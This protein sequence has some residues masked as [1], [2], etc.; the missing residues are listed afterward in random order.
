M[1]K[2]ATVV[3]ESASIASSAGEPVMLPRRS[4]TSPRSEKRFVCRKPAGLWK[5]ADGSST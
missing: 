2:G 1:K 4:E 3:S 5:S